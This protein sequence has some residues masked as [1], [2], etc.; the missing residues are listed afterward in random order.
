VAGSAGAP[1]TCQ[2]GTVNYLP[3]TE[4]TPATPVITAPL[5]G[6]FS[7]DGTLFF[8]STAGDNL[9]HT[10]DVQ[11]LTDAPKGQQLA[12]NLPACTPGAD[13]DC[14][15]PTGSPAT[16]PATVITVKPRSTT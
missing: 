5:A 14:L 1:P 10:I 7:P 2:P 4:Q 13:P 8:V 15:L 3:L 16:V 6:A 9:I 11:T 12:P